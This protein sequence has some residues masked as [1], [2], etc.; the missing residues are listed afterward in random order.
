MAGKTT[1]QAA[2]L[3]VQARTD[4]PSSVSPKRDM[5]GST[6]R[7]GT[8]EGRDSRLAEAPEKNP[9]LKRIRWSQRIGQL[10]SAFCVH[11]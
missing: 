7:S 4:V 2:E 3:A 8:V 11:G 6:C 10:T 5:A 9:C 1:R